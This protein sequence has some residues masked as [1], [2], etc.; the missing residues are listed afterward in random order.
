M[1]TKVEEAKH[2]EKIQISMKNYVNMSWAWTHDLLHGCPATYPLH[3]SDQLITGVEEPNHN[4]E[5]VKCNEEPFPL[6]MMMLFEMQLFL[7]L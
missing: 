3:Q 1:C 6:H 7:N 2:N 4:E 5:I